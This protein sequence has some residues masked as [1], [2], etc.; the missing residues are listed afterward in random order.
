[1]LDPRGP[2]GPRKK[3]QREGPGPLWGFKT[4][5]PEPIWGARPRV[6]SPCMDPDLES[7]AP[8]R[9]QDLGPGPHIGVLGNGVGP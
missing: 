4:V 8:L 3:L 5:G 7:L 6:P 1:M 2:R 9:H